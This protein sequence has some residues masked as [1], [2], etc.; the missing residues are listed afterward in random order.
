MKK[1][2]LLL[3]LSLIV[4]FVVA[5]RP[6]LKQMQS[7][8]FEAEAADRVGAES[9]LLYSFKGLSTPSN[10]SGLWIT[11]KYFYIDAE[12]SSLIMNK[13]GRFGK[14]CWSINNFNGQGLFI[15]DLGHFMTNVMPPSDNTNMSPGYYYGE[16]LQ[17]DTAAFAT[18]KIQNIGGSVESVTPFIF[19]NSSSTT[20]DNVIFVGFVRNLNFPAGKNITALIQH[21][22]EG[23]YDGNCDSTRYSCDSLVGFTGLV[24][25]IAKADY[26]ESSVK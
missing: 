1:C 11:P 26:Y 18:K 21:A 19:T 6:E 25:L 10:N 17:L 20:K 3:A 14:V 22:E 23:P 4:F 12:C 16:R 9:Y 2:T 8:G 13:N 7:A 15:K 24:S 5:C